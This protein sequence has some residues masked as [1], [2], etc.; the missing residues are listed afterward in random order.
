MSAARERRTRIFWETY[1]DYLDEKREIATKTNR[2]WAITCIVKELLKFH[3][4][5]ELGLGNDEQI[6]ETATSVLMYIVMAGRNMKHLFTLVY[7]SQADYNALID[8]PPPSKIL[9]YSSYLCLLL[10]TEIENEEEDEP[11]SDDHIWRWQGLL[12]EILLLLVWYTGNSLQD[13]AYE[14]HR[15]LEPRL[16]AEVQYN[17]WDV[18][19]RLYKD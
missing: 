6:Q 10:K 17:G 5:L 15:K 8:C 1:S 3:G 7:P 14:H 2:M 18:E 13:L 16:Y 12:R 4:V 19:K 9:S 11:A